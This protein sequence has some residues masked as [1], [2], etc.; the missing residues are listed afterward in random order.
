M[1]ISVNISRTERIA[2][3]VV[4]LAGV[5]VAA[6]LLLD[7]AS[8]VAITLEVLLALAGLDLIVTAATGHCPLYKRLGHIPA[9]LRGNAS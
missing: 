3:V 4:G 9:S 1:S 2:R 6:V 7:A 8:P 5:V